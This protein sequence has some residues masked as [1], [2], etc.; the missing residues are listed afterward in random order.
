MTTIKFKKI[1]EKAVQPVRTNGAG[2]DIVATDIATDIN[3]RFQV[4]LVYRTGIGVEIPEGYVG[5]VC[6]P[7]DI[8]KKTLSMCSSPILSG[9]IDDEVIVRYTNT[10][11]GVP[12]VYNTGDVIAKLFIIK[13]ED[14]EFEEFIDTTDTSA[15]TATQSVPE[16]EGEPTNSEPANAG[17]G[18]EENIPEQAQ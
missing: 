12:A 1:L 6:T 17:S 13:A 9:N 3:E 7:S 16:T 14:A 8:Y 15:P 10:S 2:Y 18:G 5:I 11:N 4:E